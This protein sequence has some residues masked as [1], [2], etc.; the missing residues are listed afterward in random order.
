VL[1]LPGVGVCVPDLVFT[2][3][4]A[5]TPVYLEVL[6]YWSRAAVWRRVELAEAGLPHRVIWAVSDRLRVSE[7]AL[8][9]D[10]P[11]SLYVYKG[12]MNPRRILKLLEAR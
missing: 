3:D 10:L 9:A 2:R 7:A 5:K 6:G 8:P 11:A 4:G 1:N 12:V